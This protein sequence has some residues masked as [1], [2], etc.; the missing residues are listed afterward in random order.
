MDLNQIKVPIPKRVPKMVTPKSPAP[1]DIAQAI[2]TVEHDAY[3]ALVKEPAEAAGITPPPEIPGP[4][5]ALSMMLGP[6]QN[7]FSG[8]IKQGGGQGAQRGDVTEEKK[9]PVGGVASRGS[10]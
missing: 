2:T 6:L 5:T 8:M 10:L 9:P 3:T 7:L 4:G 1:W